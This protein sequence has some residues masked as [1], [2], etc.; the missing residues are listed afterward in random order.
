MELISF[1]L[2]NYKSFYDSGVLR[3]CS[4]FNAIVGPNNVGKSA[5]LQAVAQQFSNVPHR[6]ISAKPT[7]GSAVVP[8]SE[9][10]YTIQCKGS[11]LREALLNEGGNFSIHIPATAG[12][13]QG[14]ARF[15]PVIEGVL[16]EL[17]SR[18]TLVLDLIR[19]GKDAIIV[20]DPSVLLSYPIQGENSRI[21]VNPVPYKNAF[22][23]AGT[24]VGQ[25]SY[26]PA[27]E[28][29]VVIGRIFQRRIY[30]FNGW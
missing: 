2:K 29:G 20:R 18:D 21:D 16:A 15:T 1:Q 17:F 5:L 26:N 10:H 30:Y 6:S 11:E 22:E 12:V 25:G 7:A 8:Y 14:A 23:Y 28:L 27:L 24:R 3:F 9:S 4:G 19:D 13:G